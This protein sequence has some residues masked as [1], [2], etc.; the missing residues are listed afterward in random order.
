MVLKLSFNNSCPIWNKLSLCQGRD[1]PK[2]LTSLWLSAGA[3]YPTLPTI[4][5]SCAIVK[6]QLGKD[7]PLFQRF[8]TAFSNWAGFLF[9]LVNSFISFLCIFFTSILLPTF[10][11]IYIYDRS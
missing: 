6:H 1:N 3:Q 8:L 7:K 2:I 10:K 11:N 4:L 9:K 5:P